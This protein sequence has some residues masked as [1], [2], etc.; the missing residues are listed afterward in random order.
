[1]GY[2]PTGRRWKYVFCL[3][4]HSSNSIHTKLPYKEYMLEVCD[5]STAEAEAEGTPRDEASL[6]TRS[7]HSGDTSSLASDHFSNLDSYVLWQKNALWKSLKTW[8]DIWISRLPDACSWLM[9]ANPGLSF[10]TYKMETSII[11]AEE[12]LDEPL[13]IKHFVN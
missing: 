7:A 4:Y 1:M 13:Y 9:P 6:S 2:R 8:S 11:Q 12:W 3:Y 5:I 10:S